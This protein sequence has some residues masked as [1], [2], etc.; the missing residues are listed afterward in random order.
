MQIENLEKR[1]VAHVA[2]ILHANSARFVT[3]S[4]D[5][6]IFVSRLGAMRGLIKLRKSLLAKNQNRT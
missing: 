5:N 3:D 1:T 4:L 2:S 6:P